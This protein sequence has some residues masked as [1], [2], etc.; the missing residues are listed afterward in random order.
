MS[1]YASAILR[2]SGNLNGDLRKTDLNLVPFP[3][4]HFFVIARAPLF[5]PADVKHVK[6]IVQEIADQRLSSRNFLANFKPNLATQEVD[7]IVKD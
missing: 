7:E 2:F 4:L 5:A 1:I 3:C 6:V